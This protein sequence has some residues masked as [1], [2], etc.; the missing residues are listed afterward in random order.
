MKR[1]VS[2]EEISDGKLYDLNDLVKAD[3]HDCEGCFECCCGMGESIILDPFDIYR[4]TGALGKSFEQLLNAHLELH[5]VDG[6]ILPN[7]R[8]AGERDC[9]TFLNEE[10]RCSI[11]PHRPGIC[12]LFPLGRVYENGSF[13]YFLQTGECQK[14]NRS[15]I[16]VKKWIDTPDAGRNAQFILAWHDFVLDLQELLTKQPDMEAAKKINLYV[17]ETF[18]FQSWD[19]NEDFYRQFEERLAEA[20]RALGRA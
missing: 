1:E 20:K 18:F 12:R 14:K 5:V 11:H 7:L 3:C 16:R 15:K 8:M 19:Q 2:L 4:L 6:V 17:L 13:R 9:C 10:G